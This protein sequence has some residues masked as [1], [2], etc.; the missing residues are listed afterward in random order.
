MDHAE[1]E[2]QPGKTAQSLLHKQAKQLSYRLAM[3][4]MNPHFARGR[5]EISEQNLGTDERVDA[6]QPQPYLCRLIQLIH[7]ATIHWWSSTTRT[8][9]RFKF[10]MIEDVTCK[11]F[12]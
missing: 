9:P 7:I 11:R 5:V 12:Y 3:E 6:F 4:K 10:A 8:K 1:R 2:V